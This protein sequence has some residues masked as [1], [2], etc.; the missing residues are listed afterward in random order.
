MT[1]VASVNG[2]EV[3]E[4]IAIGGPAMVRAAAENDANETIAA[5][6]ARYPQSIEG[7]TLGGTTFA[8]RQ[9]QRVA[10]DAFAHTGAHRT[11]VAERATRSVGEN[12]HQAAVL[13]RNAGAGVAQSRQL[14]GKDM[15]FNN[16]VDVDRAVWAALDLDEPALAIIKHAQQCGIEVHRQSS[17]LTLCAQ[18]CDLVRAGGGQVDVGTRPWVCQTPAREI[19]EAAPGR[20]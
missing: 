15:S 2:D 16:F 13:H 5:S 7:F 19:Y 9:R 6:P 11:A 12:S 4:L 18:D 3:I 8:Q 1:D 20:T 17:L 14:H 10:G